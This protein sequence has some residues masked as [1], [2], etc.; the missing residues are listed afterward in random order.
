MGPRRSCSSGASRESPQNPWPLAILI[1]GG[2]RWVMGSRSDLLFLG[3]DLF[4]DLR[5][6]RADGVQAHVAPGT[7][8][9]I[10]RC[11]SE[12][13]EDLHAVV[14]HFLRQLRRIEFRH[15]DLTHTTL[16]AIHQIH[17]AI[18]EPLAGFDVGEM[19]SEAM[20]PD[21]VFTDRASERGSLGTILQGV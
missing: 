12:S 20:L 14:G 13:A 19:L 9:R 18:V 21:L 10:F 6:S 17:R 8:D 1:M 3:D 4:H 11:V 2:G 5:C 7:A 16:A 15:R